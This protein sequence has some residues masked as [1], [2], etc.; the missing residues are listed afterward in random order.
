MQGFYL[1]F[2]RETVYMEQALDNDNTCCTPGFIYGCLI[3]ILL[4]F[5]FHPKKPT[6]MQRVGFVLREPEF[7]RLWDCVHPFADKEC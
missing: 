5:I 1:G 7:R 4:I 6:R 3:V 2:D